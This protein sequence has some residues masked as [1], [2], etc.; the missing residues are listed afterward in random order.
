MSVRRATV[1][2]IGALLACVGGIFAAVTAAGYAS[3]WAWHRHEVAADAAMRARLAARHLLLGPPVDPSPPALSAQ[4]ASGASAAAL[5]LALG[6]AGWLL[7]RGGRRWLALAPAVLLL[8]GRPGPLGDLPFVVPVSMDADP[9]AAD[10]ISR[11]AYATAV[12]VPVIALLAAAGRRLPRPRLSLARL[13]PP[14]APVAL[15]AAVVAYLAT[16]A[17]DRT[18]AAAMAALAVV[19]G[20]A[21]VACGFHRPWLPVVAGWVVL[22]VAVEIQRAAGTGEASLS[23]GLL[24]AGLLLALGAAAARGDLRRAWA[25]A[26]RRGPVAF[27][28]RP[29]A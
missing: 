25:R 21:L 2:S 9:A 1:L 27:A 16:A 10:W 28:G 12:A 22:A 24:P 7:A 3:M 11:A 15:A 29:P 23:A 26:F 20:G 19:L 14:V 6:A 13:A 4:V 8:L 5:L 17:D 18:A